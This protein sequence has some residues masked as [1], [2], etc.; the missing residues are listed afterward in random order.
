MK[1][2]G[3]SSLRYKQIYVLVLGVLI[4]FGMYFITLTF[5]NYLVSQNHL[6]ED[7]S[8][9]R[10]EGY[11]N[12]IENYVKKYK[13][14]VKDVRAI[15]KWVKNHKYTYLTIYSGDEILYE[16]GFWNDAY[17]TYESTG[18]VLESSQQATRN[19]TFS[20]GIYSVS[21]ID[22][23]EIKWYDLVFYISLGIFFLFLFGILIV[24]NHR[25]IARIML[26]SKEVSLIEQG[27]LDQPIY[28]KGN[29]EIAL[30][31]INADN[32]R[33]SIITRYKSEK[34]AWEANSELITSMSH[35]IRTPLTALIGYL[36][37]LESKGYH[38][39]EQL[40][41]YIKSCK[42]KSI[43]LKDLSDKLF[44]YFLVFGKETILMQEETFDARI[45]LE[46]LISEH[47]FDLSSQGF[48]VRT[49][50]ME[51]S[52]QITADIQYLKRLFDNLFSNVR[53]YAS[54]SG[55]VLVHGDSD[56]S[57]LIISISND[58]REDRTL[59]ESTGI[60][61]KTC[62][63]ITEQMNGTFEIRKNRTRFE[64]I[65]MFPIIPVG[66]E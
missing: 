44:Q 4:S 29:D 17:S 37:I 64:A 15:S 23:S 55:P 26:L 59:M 54:T 16:S 9:K 40:N 53:K 65:A 5:G 63:K 32:M 47:V 28:H 58:I 41:R 18:T 35:D 3:R 12:S 20:D 57:H 1:F 43:Q 49:G 56:G 7:A 38:S 27:G 62:Q 51:Q 66:R 11:Q 13:L 24:Y 14:S 21:I 25:I 2:N 52:C 42:E 36:E 8:R 60:G 19:I 22:S 30:L 31:A 39:E 45:L 33:N 10:L 50:F 48:D 61:L 6:N 34:E 46:Q